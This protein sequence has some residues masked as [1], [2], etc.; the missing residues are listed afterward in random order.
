MIDQTESPEFYRDG[1]FHVNERNGP[2]PLS[3]DL[4]DSWSRLNHS[5]GFP[6]NLDSLKC[7][8]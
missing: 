3:D 6:C 2:I 7:S 1:S 5:A 4:C 8:G